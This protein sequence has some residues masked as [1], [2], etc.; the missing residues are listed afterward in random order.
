MCQL[1]PVLL[2]LV[3]VYQ[4]SQA[5][6]GKP[7]AYLGG[8][9]WNLQTYQDGVCPD[10]AFNYGKRMS[11]TAG[12]IVQFFKQAQDDNITLGL[13]QLMDDVTSPS[14]AYP[15]SAGVSCLAA[16]PSQV[17]DLVP[18]PY[19]QLDMD[20]VEQYY[21]DCMDPT[22]NVFD[23]KR[24]ERLCD[25]AVAELGYRQN[26]PQA[27]LQEAMDLNHYWFVVSKGRTPLT[28]PIDPPP[29]FSDRLSELR[30]DRHI[31]VKRLKAVWQPRQRTVWQENARFPQDKTERDS[32]EEERLNLA[33]P[34]R[35][36]ARFNSLEEVGYKQAYQKEMKPSRKKATVPP[37][38]LQDE[39]VSSWNA[40]AVTNLEKPKKKRKPIGVTE[41]MLTYEYKPPP[42]QYATTTDGHSALACLKQL[43]DLGLIGE[44]EWDSIRPS[45]S[46]YASFNPEEHELLSLTVCRGLLDQNTLD[47]T[48]KYEQDRDINHVSRQALKQHL[49]TFAL[50]EIVGPGKRW[51]TMTFK[52]LRLYVAAKRNLTA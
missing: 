38:Q 10:Y 27:S 18:E 8:L 16:L 6:A 42:K 35:F 34:D 30:P 40:M 2:W 17:R 29:P 24:F 44:L 9:L 14:D 12:E 4:I 22:D 33:Q 5:A 49:G 21:G 31:R 39:V 32:W 26:K 23:V 52:T 45:P 48:L 1:L 15:I 51:T 3:S 28:K 50:C 37:P 7:E 46:E 13:R 25:Q 47:H 36:L 43:C 11:P 20:L 41:R 19:R